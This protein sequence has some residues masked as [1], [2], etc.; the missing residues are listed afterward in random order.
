MSFMKSKVS[1]E[2]K[3]LISKPVNLQLNNKIL[4]EESK[5]GVSFKKRCAAASSEDEPTR[6]N[7]ALDRKG[8]LSLENR[9]LTSSKNGAEFKL[10]KEKTTKPTCISSQETGKSLYIVILMKLLKNVLTYSKQYFS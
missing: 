8:Y 10:L 9:Y 3:Y 6:K 4:T 5:F 1:T 7:L 2:N